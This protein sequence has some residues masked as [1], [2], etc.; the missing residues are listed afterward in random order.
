MK[1]Y[2]DTL[3][4]ATTACR[5]RQKRDPLIHVYKMKKGTRH[6]GKYAVCDYTEYLNT[7]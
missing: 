6:A 2:F 4:E 1:K 3:K 5:E 7:Y